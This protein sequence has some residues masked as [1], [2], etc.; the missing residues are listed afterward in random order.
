MII[1]D[2]FPIK[3]N[4]IYYWH[5]SRNK[6]SSFSRVFPRVVFIPDARCRQ[7]SVFWGNSPSKLEIFSKFVSSIPIIDHSRIQNGSGAETE[8]CENDRTICNYGN[9]FSST[10][11]IFWFDFALLNFKTWRWNDYFK[12]DWI[13]QVQ[14]FKF[15]VFHT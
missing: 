15:V 5:H 13:P 11:L 8:P 4:S 3:V 2:I 10:L 9:I 7:R 14:S 12:V 6:I 1:N